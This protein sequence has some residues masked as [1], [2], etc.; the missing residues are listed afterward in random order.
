MDEILFDI[1]CFWD[2]YM[3]EKLDKD[4]FCRDLGG[5]IEVYEKIL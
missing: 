3:N 2:V 1:C 5:L 4:V